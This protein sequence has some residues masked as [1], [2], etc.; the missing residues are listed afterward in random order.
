MVG[1]RDTRPDDVE[2]LHRLYRPVG[3]RHAHPGFGVEL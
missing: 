1:I 3:L 2:H